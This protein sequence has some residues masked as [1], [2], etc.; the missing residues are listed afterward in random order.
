MRLSPDVTRFVATPSARATQPRLNDP[1][2]VARLIHARRYVT[3]NDVCRRCCH[4][5]C[6]YKKCRR[7]ELFT[8]TPHDRPPRLRHRHHHDLSLVG[9]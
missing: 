2:R 3:M 7:H 4:S 5:A 1:R 9:P 8:N 6:C